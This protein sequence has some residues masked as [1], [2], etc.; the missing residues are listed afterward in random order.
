MN[1]EE[2]R[3]EKRV[4]RNMEART[5]VLW[6]GKI[7][8][9][10][11]SFLG[12][13][14]LLGVLCFRYPEHLTTPELRNAYDVPTLRAVLA[15]SLALALG[16]GVLTFVLSALPSTAA[17]PASRGGTR[18]QRRMGLVGVLAASLAIALGGTSL[19]ERPVDPTPVSLGLDW[20]LL[21]LLAFAMVFILIEKTF[22][23]YP[24]QA[25]LR[26]EWR[27]DLVYY[28]VNHLL[29]GVV[30]LV[31]N[32]F[33]PLVFGWAV[34]ASLQAWIR[35]QPIFVQVVGLVF[36]ADL[37]LYWVHRWFHE[38]PFLWRFHAVHHSVEHMDWLAGSRMHVAEVL[39]FRTLAMVPLY[40]LGPDELALNSYV[41]FAALQAVFAHSN[42][43][44]PLGPL[45]YVLVTPQ[46]HHWHHSS[47]RPALD[48]NYA[49]HL[50]LWDF[51]F[52]SFHMPGE[53]WPVRYGTTKRLP[54][55]FLRQLG[56][57]FRRESQ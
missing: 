43:G 44:L 38:H 26:P 53:H 22:P 8:A 57:P 14:S 55:A 35:Q 21:S 47:E 23:K 9:Y 13:M 49:V 15:T 19:E 20:L 42:V 28:A 56:Y 11:S 33:A 32:H 39:V 48:T 18:G 34:N 29:I 37:F 31:S 2:H 1:T 27:T 4:V 41:T 3:Y 45:K 5:F 12:A 30:L 25:I 51:L 36:C 17:A 40:L 24:A 54:R 7:S 52:R 10:L 16:F 46:F 6:R 50:P